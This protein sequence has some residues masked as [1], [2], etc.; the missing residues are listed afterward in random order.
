MPTTLLPSSVGHFDEENLQY[1]HR[2][3]TRIRSKVYEYEYPNK[4]MANGE[5]LPLAIQTEAAWDDYIEVEEYDIVGVAAVIADYSKGG[6]RVGNRTRR[7]RFNIKTVGDHVGISWEEI[8]KA[9]THN[10]PIK[11]QRLKAARE[12]AENYLDKGGYSGDPAYGLPGL[13]HRIPIPRYY[14]ASRLKDSTD[15]EEMLALLN[16]PVRSLM[17]FTNEKAQPKKMVL[18]SNEFR[19]ITE[20][21]R[22]SNSDMTVL[23]AFLNTQRKQGLIDEVI[24]DIKLKDKGEDGLAAGLILPDDPDKIC[25]G[26]QLPFMM[27]PE[28]QQNLELVTHAVMRTS[29]VQAAYPMEC[30][31]FENI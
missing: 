30:L 16:A 14:S 25:L 18:P 2:E 12:A 11:E 17:E 15:P 6:P 26:V 27:L 3:L 28:Q 19:L 9:R 31:I 20:T 23:D 10:K 8:N 1:A 24:S 7:T 21:Y 22:S 5:I 29:L 13:F 4:K